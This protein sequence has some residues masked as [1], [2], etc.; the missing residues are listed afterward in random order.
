MNGMQ[1]TA[2]AKIAERYPPIYNPPHHATWPLV[3]TDQHCNA[4]VWSLLNILTAG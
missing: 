4:L 3:V 1:P 2:E